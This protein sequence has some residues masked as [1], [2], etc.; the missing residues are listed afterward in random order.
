MPCSPVSEKVKRHCMFKQNQ[1]RYDL[2]SGSVTISQNHA[3]AVWS[4]S[5]SGY[6]VDHVLAF[7]LCRGSDS[8][9]D[10]APWCPWYLGCLW[11]SECPSPCSVSP[12]CGCGGDHHRAASHA[13]DGHGH[14]QGYV[15]ACAAACPGACPVPHRHGCHGPSAYSGCDPVACLG[16]GPCSCAFSCAVGPSPCVGLIPSVGLLLS[17]SFLYPSPLCRRLHREMA[18]LTLRP[19]QHWLLLRREPLQAGPGPEP[20]HPPRLL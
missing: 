18:F 9:C 3:P 7:H 8:G 13:C 17:L 5:C 16:H 6:A 11:R 1:F 19:S 4:C 12:G 14:S 15:F 20:S 2:P 10:C